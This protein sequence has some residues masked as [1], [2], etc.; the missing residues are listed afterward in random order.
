MSE[1]AKMSAAERLALAGAVAPTLRRK[2]GAGRRV[3][4]VDREGKPVRVTDDV[5]IAKGLLARSA[6]EFSIVNGKRP[7]FVNCKTCGRPIRTSS[8]GTTPR[9]VCRQRTHKCQCGALIVGQD[10]TC[11]FGKLCRRCYER[12]EGKG[13]VKPRIAWGR[14]ETDADFIQ[15]L[16]TAG[17]GRAAAKAMGVSPSLVFKRA[18]LLGVKSRGARGKPKLSATRSESLK[19]SWAKRD[20]PPPIRQRPDRKRPPTPPRSTP[21]PST[22][23][24][25]RWPPGRPRRRCCRSRRAPSS[26]AP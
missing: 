18:K 5:E 25:P 7:I 2:A 3:T 12:G 8:R 1:P 4:V 13:R 10:G 23:A 19:A 16:L 26:P 20:R 24:A 6:I 17:N 15:C 11:G 22:A 21:P 9:T 14:W